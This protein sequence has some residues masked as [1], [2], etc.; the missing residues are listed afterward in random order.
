[1]LN[2]SALKIQGIC[3]AEQSVC[4]NVLRSLK[5]RF[6]VISSSSW[7]IKQLTQV[8]TRCTLNLLTWRKN[9]ANTLFLSES[10][11]STSCW[12]V[13][14][15]WSKVTCVLYLH[16][17]GQVERTLSA[18]ASE[19]TSTSYSWRIR[20]LLPEKGEKGIKSHAIVRA[21]HT[22]YLTEDGYIILV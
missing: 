22:R 1:M 14:Q 15:K 21:V 19:G 12:K 8:V 9:S 2:K 20:G 18:R 11:D 13:C 10:V 7:H 4:P 5:N 17:A 16:N 3:V 6:D